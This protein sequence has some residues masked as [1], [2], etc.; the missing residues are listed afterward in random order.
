M[1]RVI[2]DI[3]TRNPRFRA[4]LGEVSLTSNNMI[5]FGD[6]QCIIKDIT[7]SGAR[8]SPDYFMYTQMGRSLVAKIE[9]KDG[10]F[11]EWADEIDP[12]L[13]TP[14]AGIYMFNVDAVDEKTRDVKFTVQ[15]YHW[16]E[17]LVKNARGSKVNFARG[18]DA[19]TVQPYDIE[20]PSNAIAFQG[21]SNFIYLL[22]SV[23]AL[24]VK[25]SGGNPLTP[26]TDFWVEQ[27]QSTV[28]IPA[29]VFGTQTATV[30]SDYSSVALLDQDGFTLRNGI[31]YIFTSATTVQLS[32]W[33][34][35]GNTITATGVVRV[36]PS[37]PGNCM[38]SENTLSFTLASGETLVE[39][40][41]W[42]ETNAAAN[43]PVTVNLETGTVTLNTPLA[44]GGWCRYD[45]RTLIGQS[46]V[47]GKKM[48]SNIN[49][50][51]GMRIAIGDKVTEG[52]QCAL[53]V[54]P[55]VS[56][57]YHVYGS[58]DNIGFTVDVKANDPATASD[59]V[60]L[61]K[62]ELLIN[63]R[64]RIEAD[65]LTILEGS[66]SALVNQRDR[67]A[68]AP[69]WVASL[70]FTALADWRVYKPL[71]TRV[72][73]FNID[74]ILFTTDYPGKLKVGPRLFSVGAIGFL[75]DYR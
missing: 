13:Q 8:L 48:S 36:D 18:I 71:V 73:N 4:S 28:I 32:G 27:T 21:G 35:A 2:R 43:V 64:A 58:K 3:V 56:E 49:L 68:T 15:T 45:V 19:L 74:S 33:T 44:P 39:D 72:T 62:Q 61:L 9:D 1:L 65:G 47:V 63:R 34:P 55:N 7:G 12:T 67:S 51:L 17:G 46:T 40:Q 50:V 42:V 5:S 22:S 54:S 23:V 26:L 10:D 38:N 70:Q 20:N 6:V 14:V 60:E 11:F 41:V 59:I 37:V 24:G 75:P 52:D 53:L 16:Y 66:R 69:G 30:P 29:T 25:D 31:D 57:T